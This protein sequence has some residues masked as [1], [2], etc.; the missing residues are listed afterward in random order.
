M[1]NHIS[2]LTAPHQIII[3]LKLLHLHCSTAF[4]SSSSLGTGGP[5]ETDEFSEKFHRGGLFQFKKL[6]SKLFEA[7]ALDERC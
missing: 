7:S 1:Y 2:S 5:N 6:C 3:E 4:T